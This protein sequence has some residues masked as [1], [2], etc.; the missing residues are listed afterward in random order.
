MKTCIYSGSFDPV[1]FGHLDI[2]KR[3]SSTFDRVI[4]GVGVNSS[5]KY[6][7]S[8]KQ[9]IQFLKNNIK[10]SNVE[11]LSFD[12]LLADFAYENNARTIIK[13]VRN[14]QDFDYERLLHEI[15]ITQQSGIDTHILVAD[16]KLSHVSSSAAKELCK[17]QGLI[18]EYVPYDVKEALEWVLNGQFIVGVTGEIGMGKSCFSH[19]S[20]K[21]MN[22]DL[23]GVA[24]EIYE[25]KSPVHCEL[26]DRIINDFKLKKDFNKKELG[27]IVFNDTDKLNHLNN[28]MRIPILTMTRK[29]M[30][31]VK[32]LILLNGALLVESDYLSLCNNNV[33]LVK[34]TK[35]KQ[36][37]HL[38]ERKLSNDQIKRRIASQLNTDAKH[39]IIIEEIKKHN[40]GFCIVIDIFDVNAD[41]YSPYSYTTIRNVDTVLAEVTN[42][43]RHQFQTNP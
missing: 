19:F 33:I 40:N 38:Q 31:G 5:K 12:G 9:R 8:V 26:K 14:N 3:A 10:Q 29:K 7:F 39:K 16:Q 4:V 36:L 13:G 18:H 21:D 28:L 20:R 1:T 24:H 35:E 32:G 25:S 27:E 11:V 15:T 41:S 6:T 23:D 37:A 42:G 22:V 34:T 2:I 30:M 43:L 17:F